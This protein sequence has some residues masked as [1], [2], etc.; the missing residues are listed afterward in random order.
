MRFVSTRG[1]KAERAFCD[2]LTVGLARDGGL[3]MP[4]SWPKLP[5]RSALEDMAYPELVAR[6]LNLF[7]PFQSHSF[8]TQACHRAFERFEGDETPVVAQLSKKLWSMELFHGPTAAF[9][10]F[11]MFP[12]A[13]LIDA[14]L[15][16]KN[17]K[18]IM[19]CATSGDTG[20][21]AASAFAGLDTVS[22][23]ILFPDNRISSI[24]RRQMTC[25][26][27]KNIHALAVQGDFD[28]CQNMV[29]HMMASND[30]EII[31]VNSI[32]FIRIAAQIAYYIYCCLKIGE[33]VDFIV[34]TGNFGNAFSC[35]I[36]RQLGA[37]IGRI[38]IVSN[39]NDVL[40]RFFDSG[41]MEATQ[42]IP[43]LSPSMDI[44]IASNF[45]RYLWR[46]HHQEGAVITE[47]QLS[48]KEKGYYTLSP[49]YLG[50]LQ[51]DFSA[52]SCKRKETLQEMQSIK[53]EYGKEICPHTATGF[54]AARQLL[55]ESANP[56]VVLETAHLAKF[57]NAAHEAFGHAPQPHPRLNKT[58]KER[59]HTIVAKNTALQD[60]MQAHP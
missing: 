22:A 35:Y 49:E 9:K 31:A 47:M 40:P 37:S 53:A 30:D 19:L 10:D 43:S 51:K 55:A 11:A 44:Q 38:I 16:K 34:P 14:E 58:G 6:I 12:L 15:K 57:P 13:A 23:F 25:I 56:L 32:N 50:L 48:L 29:K 33:T 59:V 36:A 7:S 18:S 28:D 8:I 27:Q 4:R 17:K 46:L 2:L 5:Q 60:F 26:P 1:H 20:A 45:E 52:F 24:Q 41:K 54:Y 39:E 21:S 42:T 3:Y